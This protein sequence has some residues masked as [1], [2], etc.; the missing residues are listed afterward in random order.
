MEMASDRIGLRFL[1]ESDAEALLSLYLRNRPFFERYSATRED[2]FYTLDS[3][4]EAIRQQ[5]RLREQ[6]ASY[7]FGIFLR[8]TGELIGDIALTEVQRSN[9]QGC[10]LGYS[11]DEQH[12]GKGYMTEAVRLAVGYAFDE[13]NLHRIEAGVM[14]KNPGSMRVLEKAGF[15]KEGLARKNVNINGRWEDH[16]TFAILNGEHRKQTS[17]AG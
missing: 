8:K 1:E 12:N 3:R 17:P 16:W 5:K 11:L 6:D 13:L 2:S 14:P 15:Q 4:K 10:W 7:C 9:L